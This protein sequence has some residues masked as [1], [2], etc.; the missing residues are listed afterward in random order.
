MKALIQEHERTW[1]KSGHKVSTPKPPPESV[2]QNVL[3]ECA[4]RRHRAL[5]ICRKV[6]AK[7]RHNVLRVC[8]KMC[9][10]TL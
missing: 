9:A 8:L 3:A 7:V 2:P 10:R 4:Q 5:K 1:H 6:C